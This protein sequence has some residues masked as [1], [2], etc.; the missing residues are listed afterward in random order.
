MP[1]RCTNLGLTTVTQAIEHGNEEAEGPIDLV[2]FLALKVEQL[3]T[4]PA[5]ILLLRPASR[6]RYRARKFV[7]YRAVPWFWT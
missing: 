1:H 2:D 6:R 5:N 7:V 3:V 4:N